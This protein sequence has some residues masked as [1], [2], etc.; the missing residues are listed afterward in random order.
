M[1]QEWKEAD[2]ERVRAEQAEHLTR[3]AAL[4]EAHGKP[5]H[6]AASDAIALAR[7]TIDSPD[8]AQLHA[9]L[10]RDAAQADAWMS[11]T[12]EHYGHS[13]LFRATLPDGQVIGVYDLRPALARAAEE[14]T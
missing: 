6:L 9:S 1:K 3:R 5:K 12:A 2:R 13:V 11:S 8:P 10:Y 4:I 14:A 7:A